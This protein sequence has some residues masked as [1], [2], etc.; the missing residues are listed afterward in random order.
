VQWNFLR[1]GEIES[2]LER[3]YSGR[4]NEKLTAKGHQQAKAAALRLKG[5]GV[6][7]IYSSPLPRA[8]ETAEIIGEFIGQKP[9]LEE[10]FNELRLGVWEQKSEDAIQ[11]DF[12]REWAVWNARPAELILEGRETLR[13]LLHRVLTGIEKIKLGN[14]GGNVAVV[15][16]VAVIRVLLLHTQKLDLNF[17]KTFEIPNGKIF[18][19]PGL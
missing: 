13:E 10:S 7:N 18:P 19:L 16:H 14:K 2:N 4:S 6:S 11:R 17:Y 5:L 8:V 1:H 15:T 9:I 12:P 3:I